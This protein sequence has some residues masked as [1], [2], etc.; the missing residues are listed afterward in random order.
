MKHDFY[1]DSRYRRRVRLCSLAVN[2]VCRCLPEVE[3]H[4]KCGADIIVTLVP[5]EMPGA[6]R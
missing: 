4:S 3:R 2:V 1:G 5:K 6:G